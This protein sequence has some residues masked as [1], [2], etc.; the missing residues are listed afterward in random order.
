[1]NNKI[2]DQDVTAHL[3]ECESCPSHWYF[4]GVAISC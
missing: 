4:P 3:F 2:L 1:M